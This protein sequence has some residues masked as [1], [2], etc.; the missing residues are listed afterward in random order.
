MTIQLTSIGLLLAIGV[1]PGT[2]AHATLPAF[3]V[4]HVLQMRT[5]DDDNAVPGEPDSRPRGVSLG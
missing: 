4:T 5:S 1:G 3:D 2:L